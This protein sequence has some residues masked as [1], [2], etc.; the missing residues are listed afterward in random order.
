MKKYIVRALVPAAGVILLV[1]MF[2]GGWVEPDPHRR[3][4]RA[5]AS[6]NNAVAKQEYRRLIEDD[7]YNVAYHRGYIRSNL[8]QPARTGRHLRFDPAQEQIV[9]HCVDR[10]GWQQRGHMRIV[11]RPGRGGR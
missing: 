8:R 5:L 1:N 2:L 7:F 3:I 9:D 6:G 11:S 10:R 4:E